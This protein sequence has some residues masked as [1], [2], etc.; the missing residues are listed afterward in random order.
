MALFSGCLGFIE[1]DLNSGDDRVTIWV[2]KDYNVRESWTRVNLN[3]NGW[4]WERVEIL[5]VQK[6]GEV[7]ML[8]RNQA[9]LVYDPK[10]MRYRKPNI[11][12]LPSWFE[13]VCH[14]GSLVS[15]LGY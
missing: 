7:L 1:Y 8:R 15:P 2:M 6:N 11:V 14:V 5:C 9:L 13:A 12:G 4:D 10:T 3:Q